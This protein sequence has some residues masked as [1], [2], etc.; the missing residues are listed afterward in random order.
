V[1]YK[2]TTLTYRPY[3][4]IISQAAEISGTTNVDLQNNTGGILP[5]LKPVCVNNSGGMKAI[6][7]NNETD[8][9]NSVGVLIEQ[10]LNSEFGS[11]TRVGKINNVNS[12]GFAFRDVIYVNKNGDLT[13]VVPVTGSNGF[14]AGDF[15]V[16]M[17][18]I[19]KNQTDTLQK[20]LLV[21]V[22]I[23]GQLS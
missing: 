19:V 20:D 10:T 23:V 22:E 2:E 21:S 15:V 14:V 13:N 7:V 1:Q 5:A 11:V 17:G 4:A 3:N 9:L 6:D 16:R 12:L 18:K 8:C